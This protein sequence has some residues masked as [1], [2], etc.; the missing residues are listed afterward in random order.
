MSLTVHMKPRD[1]VLYILAAGQ[2]ETQNSRVLGCTVLSDLQ[3]AAK[4]QKADELDRSS[5]LFG[6]FQVILQLPI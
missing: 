1:T 5:M 3:S 4:T 2:W 6:H